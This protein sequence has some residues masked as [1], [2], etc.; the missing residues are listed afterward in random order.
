M[1]WNIKKTPWFD[2]ESFFVLLLINY[3][4][5]GLSYFA[6]AICSLGVDFIADF[7]QLDDAFHG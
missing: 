4:S 1:T 3:F 6:N 7:Q 5:I 2:P